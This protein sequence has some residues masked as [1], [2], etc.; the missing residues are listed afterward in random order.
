MRDMVYILGPQ[1]RGDY[2]MTLVSVLGLRLYLEPS[3][4]VSRLLA[5]LLI[6][7]CWAYLGP[8]GLGLFVWCLEAWRV[9]RRGGYCQTLR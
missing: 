9:S 6:A 4:Q 3:G 1:R 7:D 8:I 5:F 2:I